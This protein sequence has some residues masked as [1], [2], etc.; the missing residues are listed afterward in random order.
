MKLFAMILL[1]VLCAFAPVAGGAD[2]ET[3]ITVVAT[4]VGV[5]PAKARTNAVRNA[6][7]QAIGSCVD[8]DAIVRNNRRLQDEVLRVSGDYVTD[9]RLLSQDTSE[10]GLASVKLEARIAATRLKGALEALGLSPRCAVPAVSA[11]AD[12]AGTLLARFPQGAYNFAVARPESGVRDPE[13][14]RTKATIPI[15]IIWDSGFVAD[16]R[17]LLAKTARQELKQVEIATFKEGTNYRLARDSRIVCIT[18]RHPNRTG[19][20]DACY[21]FAKSDVDD[22]AGRN[23][24]PGAFFTLLTGKKFVTVSIYFKGKTGRLVESLNYEFVGKEGER[25]KRPASEAPSKAG[26]LLRS[27]SFNPPNIFWRDPDT[28]ILYILT[29]EAF[30]LSTNVDLDTAG[31]NDI[32]NIEVGISSYSGKE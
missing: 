2:G 4:G 5:D 12:E 28:D 9:S 1:S 8:A 21:A 32:T 31:V 26:L 14:G 22:S 17:G 7:E 30:A 19:K 18:E 13:S 27:G 6:V 3:V 24:W 23:R 10:D 20:A 25:V 16:L 15:T 29:G 11:S